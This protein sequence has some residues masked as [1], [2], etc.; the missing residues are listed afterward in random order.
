MQ[1]SYVITGM[2]RR[3]NQHGIKVGPEYQESGRKTSHPESVKL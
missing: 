1:F 3:T 2:D